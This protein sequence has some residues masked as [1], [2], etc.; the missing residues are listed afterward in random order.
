MSQFSRSSTPSSS[1]QGTAPSQRPNV[2]LILV[3]LGLGLVAV[4]ANSVYINH[5]R[6]VQE[7]NR[8]TIYT[9]V[10]PVEPGDKLRREDIQPVEMYERDREHYERGIGAITREAL[11][12]KIGQPF[13]K[14][15]QSGE[16]LTYNLF[17]T[18]SQTG[19]YEIREGMR[20][21][22]L[23]IDRQT[24]P[25]ILMPNDT[26]DIMAYLD[27]P[28]GR[29]R[30]YLVQERV[31]VLAVGERTAKRQGRSRSF[32]T[33]TIEVTPEQAKQLSTILRYTSDDA[34]QLNPR[35][36]G[37]LQETLNGEINP[38]VLSLLGIAS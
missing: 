16:Y 31:R 15:A 28:S 19:S 32:S 22:V 38:Q 33:V 9:L 3:A 7:G 35:N 29:S 30:T 37:D 13:T 14:Y 24:T 21:H 34:F 20:A 11:S 36:P 1:P 2:T 18:E 5:I 6:S 23:P 8:F 26:V 17:T 25:P 10:R 27:P 4:I 12:P